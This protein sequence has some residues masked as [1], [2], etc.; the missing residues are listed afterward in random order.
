ML[1]FAKIYLVNFT[2]DVLAFP[3]DYPQDMH[4]KSKT[5]KGLSTDCDSDT[6]LFFFVCLLFEVLNNGTAH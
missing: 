1:T 4:L 6:A 2:I 3:D 5:I